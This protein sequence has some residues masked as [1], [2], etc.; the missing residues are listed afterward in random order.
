M[1]LLVV[2]LAADESDM[3]TLGELDALRSRAQVLFEQPDHPL[4]VR[5]E[6][7]GT[8]CGPLDGDPDPGRSDLAVVC[9][10]ASQLVLD[11]ARQGAEVIL[12]P[13]SLPDA[14]S[15]AHAAPT[16]RR[17][18]SALITLAVIMARLRS[19]DGCP[20]D[21]EQTHESLKVHLIEEAHEVLEAIDA[22]ATSSELTEELGDVLLQV[23]FHSRI[24]E[25]D[26]RFTLG[27][28]ANAI[29][30][31]LV[32]RH[33]HVFGDTEV[34]DADEVVRNW[35]TIKSAEKDRAD[36]FAGIPKSLPALLAAYKTQKRAA[37]LGWRPHRETARRHALE[38][39][40]EG[41]LE[42][43]LFWLVALARSAGI[44]PESALLRATARF[45][46]EVADPAGPR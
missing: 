37:Q 15:A 18:G 13:A 31:K 44:D 19:D 21:R 30:T 34:A 1:T 20:W 11:L 40:T 8:S 45:R 7:A 42:A 33:P 14:L 46:T 32:N 3:L 23:A 41:D 38:A 5:L 39:V 35:E 28:V 17:S 22:G 16:A 2:P 4:A 10:P 12:G 25:Q 9:D 26:G 43:A 36:P 24:A 29:S 6:D 27:D